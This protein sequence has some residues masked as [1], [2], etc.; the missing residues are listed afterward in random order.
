MSNDPPTENAEAVEGQGQFNSSTTT[1][2]KPYP[3]PEAEYLEIVQN[4]D[5]F[6]QNLQSFHSYFGTKFK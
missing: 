1:K 2:N 4:P 6:L 5:V 3:K